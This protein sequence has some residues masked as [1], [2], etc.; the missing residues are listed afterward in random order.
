MNIIVWV[1]FS[2][3]L[4]AGLL[5]VTKKQLST[6]DKL[7][8]ALLFLLAIDSANIGI[9]ALSL[10]LNIIPSSFFLLNP[11]FYLYSRSLI[12]VNFKLKPTQLLHLIPYIFLEFSNHYFLLSFKSEIFF[13][14]DKNLWIR[15]L[16][17]L[18][19]FIS[20]IVYNTLSII[21][22]HKHR[23]N[24]K[25]EFS[26][27]ERNQRLSWLMFI[28]ILYTVYVVT[29]TILGFLNF[30]YNDFE[31][32]KIYNY[33]AS[34]FITFILGFYGIKQEQ[35]YKK[36]TTNIDNFKDDEKYKKSKLTDKKKND[37]KDLLLLYFKNEKPYLNSDLN[38]LF[39]SK[40]LNIPKYQLTEILNTTIGK[41]FFQFVN[42]YRVN[43]VKEKLID[44]D[45][46]NFS[47]EAIGYDCGF[48]SKSSFFSVFKNETGQTPLQFKNSNSKKLSEGTDMK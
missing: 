29:S 22:V 23:M 3:A 13:N 31:T 26:N 25:N 44:P 48:S 36:H 32:S 34:L 6:P 42:E 35:I 2:I 40:K 7:L 37:I 30:I 24:L 18:L 4:F 9:T 41:N 10:N 21:S 39:L 17:A 8:S 45:N 5:I 20:L 46:D 33:S 16:Y 27:I 19:F 43:T 47:I 11:A 12:N 28:V 15:I 1:A 14:I 38:M